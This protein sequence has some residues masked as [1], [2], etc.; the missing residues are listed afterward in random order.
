VPLVPSTKKVKLIKRQLAKEFIKVFYPIT[1]RK[2]LVGEELGKQ[3]GIILEMNSKSILK[4]L[5]CFFSMLFPLFLYSQGEF[6]NWYFGDHAGITFN[7]GDPPVALTDCSTALWVTGTTITVSDSLGHLLFY[8]DGV[9]VYNRH[10]FVMPNGHGLNPYPDLGNQI[11][12]Y[13]PYLHDSNFY[14]VFTVGIPWDTAHRNPEGLRYSV[15]NMQLDTALG[16]IPSGQKNILIPSAWDAG[17]NVTGTRHHN[18]KFAWV[19][20][21]KYHYTSCYASYLVNDTGLDTTAV[22]SNSLIPINPNTPHAHQMHEIK[23]SPDGYKL[24]AIYDYFNPITPISSV[25]EVCNFNSQTG[26]ITPLFLIPG[27]FLP[28]GNRASVEFSRDSKY[29]YTTEHNIT[30][31]QD[32][33][34]QFD[35]TKPDSLSFA[36][37]R[38]TIGTNLWSSGLQLGP[39][40]KIYCTDNVSPHLDLINNPSVQGSGCN[41]QNNAIDLLGHDGF[42]GLPQLLQRY[43]VYISHN[44]QCRGD[45]VS[46]STVLF[47]PVDSLSWSFGDPVSGSLNYSNLP[48]PSH[49]YSSAGTYNVELIVRH[50]DKRMDTAWQVVTIL[51]G[52]QPNLGPNL[53]ICIGDSV[54]FDAGAC[55]GCTYL[56]KNL[57]SGATVGTSQTFRTGQAGTYTA[58]VTGSNGCIGRDTVQLSTTPVPAVSNSP[59]LVKTICTGE[60]TNIPLTSSPPG[61]MFHWT[62]SLSSGNVTGFSAD[63]GLVINQVLTNPLATPGI[64]IYHITPKIG[65]CSGSKVDYQVT[66]NPGDSVKVSISA[67]GNNICSG[68]SVTF[69][70]I[71][72]Y[73]GSS[74][75]YL[76]KVNGMNAGTN[77]ALF[78]YIPLN[79]DVVSCI[80]TSSNTICVFNNPATSNSITMMVNPQMPVSLSITSSLNPVCAGNTVLFTANPINEGPSPVYQWKVNGVN[81]GT[82]SSTFTYISVNNDQ[83]SCELTSSLTVCVTNNPATSNTIVMQVDQNH[84][85]S[86]TISASLNP[87]CAGNTVLFTALPVNPGLTP[88]YQWKVNGV[89]AGTNSSNYTYIPLNNDQVSCVMTSSLTSCVTNNPA[90]SNMV[91]MTV[92]PNYTVSVTI[93]APSD[94]VCQGTSVQLTAHPVNEGLTPIYQWKVNGVNT[95]ANSSTFSYTPVNADVVSCVLTSSYTTCTTNNPATSNAVTMTVFNNLTAG[96]SITAVP[97]PFCS[98]SIVNCSATPTNGGFTPSYQW[99]VNGVNAGTNASTYSYIPQQ[100]DIVQCV[101]NSSLSCITNNPVTSNTIVMNSLAAPSVSFT[102][103]FDSVTTI[104][105]AAFKLKGG[106]PIGGVYSGPGVN[107]VTGVFTP[108]S[109]GIGTKTITYFYQNSFSCANSKS[110]TIIV[111]AAP[112]FNC[113]QNLTDIRDNKVYPTV[114][115]GTQCW[116]QK[117][118]NYGSSI[119]GTT[120]QTDNCMNEKY[121]YSDNPANCNIYGGLY[122]WDEVMAYGNTPGSQGLCPPGWH[123]PTQAEWMVLFNNNLTQGMAGKPLQDSIFNGFRAK[124]S[125][126]VYSNIS[127]KFQGFATLYWS[128]NPYGAIKALSHG[129]NLQNFSVSDYYSNRSNAFAVRCLKD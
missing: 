87:V 68:T 106:V 37:S 51:P 39:D 80:L 41:Y 94:T 108:S 103:C 83:I 75:A 121:C 8:S 9:K 97:N 61:A 86:L 117:N 35:A 30:T 84:P 91:T 74:P 34:V 102:L 119:Q 129:M 53:T 118:L 19:V 57:G 90:T 116:M 113:G 127:W 82:N 31:N 104:N 45:T 128:S 96:I 98:G 100:G 65:S 28:N 17:K 18:N 47:P 81:S 114:Q 10:H 109:A 13:V 95:G 1:F 7:Y 11:V 126:I 69:T 6:N 21:R 78:T 64:V 92:N 88:V 12:F 122:Q 54:T 93:T 3:K 67:S 107:S 38:D 125:G 56:W 110:K 46:F 44:G 63:S 71:P 5:C 43:Y 24:I 85:V 59:P 32:Q 62:A 40:G 58:L 25:L 27:L 15:I 36:Q 50:N 70:A 99:K 2:I 120:E 60:S 33:I 4:N 48:T 124:E 89:N 16:D 49:I 115:L 23:I 22:L 20:T 101:M 73:G 29:L 112:S 111:Q 105:A 52:P 66:V 76:W 26:Q 77:S 55:T 42:S 14:Y 123:I 79:N 72:T